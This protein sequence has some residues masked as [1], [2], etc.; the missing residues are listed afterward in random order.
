[1][2]DISLSKFGKS[3]GL[4]QSNEIFP[5]SLMTKKFIISGGIA[6][7]HQLKTGCEKDQLD[8]NELLRKLEECPGALVLGSTAT[9]QYNMINYSSHTTVNWTSKS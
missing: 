4:A 5:H 9:P 6:T 8:C 1:M 2:I 7:I 3:F